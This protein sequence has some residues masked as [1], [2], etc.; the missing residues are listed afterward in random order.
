MGVVSYQET[1]FIA[2]LLVLMACIY[3]DKS[4][5]MKDYL[6]VALISGWL[7]LPVEHWTVGALDG[8]DVMLFGC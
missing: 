7:V 3:F 4:N 5:P 8:F 2:V 6:A 1:Y